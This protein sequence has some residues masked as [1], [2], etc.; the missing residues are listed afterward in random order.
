MAQVYLIEDQ[1]V[2]LRQR[3]DEKEMSVLMHQIH[4][5]W[6]SL[7]DL[8]PSTLWRL[9]FLHHDGLKEMKNGIGLS[10]DLGPPPYKKSHDLKKTWKMV[11]DFCY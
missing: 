10:K 2:K 9:A 5:D 8:D 6:K 3:N 4:H 1:V 11:S 7:S